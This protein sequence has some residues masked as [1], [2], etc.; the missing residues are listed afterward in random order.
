M[1]AALRDST[2]RLAASLAP[3]SSRASA[4]AT[5]ASR[6]HTAA[7][8]AVAPK[9]PFSF[10]RALTG[11]GN[12]PAPPPPAAPQPPTPA[13]LSPALDAAAAVAAAS[14]AA[15]A[16]PLPDALT[17]LRDVAGHLRLDPGTALAD[18]PPAW[19]AMHVAVAEYTRRFCGEPPLPL[20]V[21]H[22][23]EQ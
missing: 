13:P 23:A 7:A 15:A 14:A 3:A 4:V 20:A 9:Q 10:W 16:Y 11:A 17:P 6:E 19:L 2:L 5:A 18:L 12:K 1:A 22:H 8:A 21:S